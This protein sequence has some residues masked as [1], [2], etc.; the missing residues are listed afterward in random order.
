M[1]PVPVF[2]QNQIHHIRFDI[3]DSSGEAKS[4][5]IDLNPYLGN[6]EK[7]GNSYEISVLDESL[8][9]TVMTPD[10]TGAA[11]TDYDSWSWNSEPCYGFS[12][13]VEYQ[14]TILVCV[15][16]NMDSKVWLEEINK[17]GV[18][19]TIAGNDIAYYVS[20]SSECA[21]HTIIPQVNSG[22]STIVE[23][24]YCDTDVREPAE[25]RKNWIVDDY[26]SPRRMKDFLETTLG[27]GPVEFCNYTGFSWKASYGL[28][29]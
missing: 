4:F 9:L 3:L 8:G 29:K 18:E 28:G 5:D 13:L 14:D 7:K 19:V 17:R 21:S 23:K 24:G 2:C 1:R 22:T 26:Y 11:M 16:G 6:Y 25:N 27:Y 10:P 20:D 12:Y 15:R